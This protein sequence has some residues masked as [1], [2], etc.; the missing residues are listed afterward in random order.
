MTYEEIASFYRTR[1]GV[2]SER[3]VRQLAECTRFSHRH[4]G[5]RLRIAGKAMTSILFFLDG[6]AR[7]Y[8]I[9]DE[10]YESVMGFSFK[11]GSTSQ[12]AFGIQK[13]YTLNVDA[14]TE[15]DTLELPVVNLLHV[16]NKDPQV[17]RV[18]QRVM[19][20]MH[21]AN[22]Q[23]QIATKMKNGEDRYRWFLK[24]YAP[25]ADVVAQKDVASFLGLRPQSLS[26]IKTHMDK[27][28]K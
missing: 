28:E 15:M 2:Q 21:E 7:V 20:E 12:G 25:I 9:D 23:W 11:P 10:G 8:I 3:S 5:D 16:M 17:G 6:V 22:I 18:V 27:Q 13:K 19:A 14:V 4:K 24:E 26:R 1:L